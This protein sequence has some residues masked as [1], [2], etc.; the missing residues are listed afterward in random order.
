M[1]QPAIFENRSVR[2]GFMEVMKEF[3]S[4]GITLQ[5]RYENSIFLYESAN[6]AIFIYSHRIDED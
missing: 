1:I 6:K 2:A 5:S 3:S 4:S